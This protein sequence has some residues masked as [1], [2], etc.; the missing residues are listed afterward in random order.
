MSWFGGY[1][2]RKKETFAKQVS[3][4]LVSWTT[5]IPLVATQGLHPE[6]VTE[7]ILTTTIR[8]QVMVVVV[9]SNKITHR[10]LPGL[11]S[12]W[13]VKVERL[14]LLRVRTRPVAPANPSLIAVEVPVVSLMIILKSD[15]SLDVRQS[16][17]LVHRI[18]DSLLLEHHIR[19]MTV[20]STPFWK[21]THSR[22]WVEIRTR[23]VLIV[24]PIVVTPIPVINL[25]WLSIFGW[26]HRGWWCFFTLRLFCVALV[27]RLVIWLEIGRFFPVASVLWRTT[28]NVILLCLWS[29]FLI[30]FLVCH[31][32][33]NLV[34][35]DVFIR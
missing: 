34:N 12:W 14:L 32:S 29:L 28:S 35:C 6:H 25:W 21:A 13:R 20:Q 26:W 1:F 18:V 30:F 16:S 27:W 33:I 22:R 19:R 17:A 24:R 8:I 5:I 4:L 10:S 9:I 3:S 23:R 11:I 7:V 31:R 2:A 15:R